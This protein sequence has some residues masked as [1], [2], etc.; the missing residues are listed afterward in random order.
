MAEQNLIVGLVRELPLVVADCRVIKPEGSHKAMAQVL[1]RAKKITEVT[2]ERT[3]HEASRVAQELQ[4]LRGGLKANYHNE[5]HPVTS[6]GRALDNVF[7]ELDRPMEIEYKRIDKLVSLYQDDLRRESDLAKAK[8]EA[9]QRERERVERERLATL[10]RQQAE[11]KP[12]FVRVG[13][14]I[15]KVLESLLS[16]FAIALNRD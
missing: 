5:K 6:Y 14:G 2:D 1:A 10:E 3:Q 13:I 12:G 9:Q 4:G 11:V 7:K 15:G 16:L 8:A